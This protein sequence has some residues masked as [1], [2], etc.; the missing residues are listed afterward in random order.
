MKTG[1]KQRGMKQKHILFIYSYNELC[2]PFKMN[3]N[4]LQYESW[5][6]IFPTTYAPSAVPYKSRETMFDDDPWC[7]CAAHN[8]LGSNGSYILPIHI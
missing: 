4:S 6:L 8:Y 2:I 1:R 5:T 3:N 7:P